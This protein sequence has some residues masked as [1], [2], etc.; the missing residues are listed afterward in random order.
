M[1]NEHAFDDQSEISLKDIIH[2]VNKR[3]WWLITVFVIVV[4]LV[5]AYLYKS[6]PIYQ[7]SATLWVEP[8]QSGSSLEDMLSLQTGATSTRISTEVELI[9]SRRNLVK[10]IEDLDLVSYYRSEDVNKEPVSVESLISSLSSM[11]SVSTVKDTNIVRISVE[12][13]DPA[14]AKDIANTLSY[15]YN[16]MLREL[17]QDSFTI[18]KMFIESQIQPTEND[19]INAENALRTFKEEAGIFLLDEEAKVL[20]EYV[21]LYEQQIDPYILQKEE[22][23]EESKAL[24]RMLSEADA[25]FPAYEVLELDSDLKKAASDLAKTKMKYATMS[26]IE[27]LKGFNSDTPALQVEANRMVQTISQNIRELMFSE[28][29]EQ[30]A[31]SRIVFSQLIESYTQRFLADIDISYLERL[32]DSY[33]SKMSQLPA[34]EQKLFD[35]QRELTVKEKLYTLLLENYEEAKIAEAAV[36]GTSTIIDEASLPI[37]PIKPNKK[38]MLAIGVLLGL[39]LGVLLVFLIEAFDDKVNDEEAVKRVFGNQIPILGRVPLISHFEDNEHP[40]L[41]VFNDP[42]SPLAESFKLISTNILYS[43]INAPRTMC[44]TS[45]EMGAGKTTISANIALAMAQNGLRTLVIDADMRKPRLEKAFGLLR[46]SS[47]LVNHLLQDI[48]LQTIIQK[49]LEEL[50]NLHLL[51]VGPLPPN[52][53]SLLSSERFQQALIGLKRWYDR[54]IIDLPPL[55]AASDAL[56]AARSSDGLIIVVRPGRTS[57]YGLKLA[58]ESLQNSGIPLIGV[59]MNGITRENS[60]H[61]YHYYYYYQEDGSKRTKRKRVWQYQKYGKYGK[62]YSKNNSKQYIKGKTLYDRYEKA[63]HGVVKTESS[64]ISAPPLK[65]N[66]ERL[67]NLIKTAPPKVEQ[68]SALE[69]IADLENLQQKKKAI[70]KKSIEQILNDQVLDDK[71]D[72]DKS[73]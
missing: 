45:S 66:T 67:T 58:T 73:K 39:F 64:V 13:K 33:K 23:I 36:S 69:M 42:T 40:E 29:P 72:K 11:I 24:Q 52:P 50:P 9:K 55:L 49:P 4:G 54:I 26:G 28:V 60:Y 1:E 70:T 14:L 17:A 7:A 41:I 15:V 46:S 6:I 51:P 8:S 10:I 65:E 22:A 18:R 35:L 56:I 19:V 34:L 68:K 63:Q 57:R 71:K 37:H 48:E 25:D 32:R 61:Y 30:D 38:M 27:G 31:Y 2:I 47:G 21:T 3:K 62:R 59:V 16:E 20:L 53:T 43:R 44:V 5:G 12:N